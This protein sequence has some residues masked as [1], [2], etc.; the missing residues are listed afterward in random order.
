MGRDLRECKCRLTAPVRVRMLLGAP[1]GIFSAG[2]FVIAFVLELRV[3]CEPPGHLLHHAAK[4]GVL[5]L[6]TFPG[7][8]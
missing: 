4:L 5:L 1:P 3:V 8:T 7:R 2:H 6:Q